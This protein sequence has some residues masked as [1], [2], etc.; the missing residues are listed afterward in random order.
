MWYKVKQLLAVGGCLLVAVV[1][2]GQVTPS[3][4]I[5]ALQRSV[6][7]VSSLE[8]LNRLD[9]RVVES[10]R[11]ASRLQNKYA[12]V[13]SWPGPSKY[14]ARENSEEA[15][16]ALSLLDPEY[17]YPQ[18]SFLTPEALPAYF[19]VKHNLELRKWLPRLEQV[20]R[21]VWEHI[22]QF[23]A[24]QQTLTHPASQDMAWLAGQITPETKYFLIGELHDP[25]IG[26][27]IPD[28]LHEVRRRQPKREIFLFTE[29]LM[30]GQ[31]WGK[32][33]GEVLFFPAHVPI[34]NRAT[35][36]KITVV[37]LEPSFTYR[38]DVALAERRVD[39]AG[40]T[41]DGDSM[42]ASIEGVRIRNQ[43][44][45]ALLTQYRKR[46]PEALFIIY[47]G[48]GHVDYE[49]PY[50]LGKHFAGP[51]TFVALLYPEYLAAQNNQVTNLTSSFDRWTKGAFLDRVLQ[52]NDKN[53]SQIAGFDVRIRIPS[54]YRE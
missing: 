52:F 10:Y 42:W 31:V 32:N 45:L 47:G 11:R 43:Y 9:R 23:H 21:A 36:D 15:L 35:R 13:Q 53:L 19:L 17:L 5:K 54:T 51:D 16:Q 41:M 39:L 22:P 46:Y 6:V 29:F 49:S 3:V 40:R 12:D 2:Q 14:F 27:Y 26:N 38:A 24:A 33:Q 1:A 4:G 30:D 18:T 7:P 20:R 34:W 8:L 28:L 48:N 25:A 50:A 44:W 37:G